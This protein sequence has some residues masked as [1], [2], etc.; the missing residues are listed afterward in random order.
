MQSWVQLHTYGIQ[1]TGEKFKKG[2]MTDKEYKSSE[3][4]IRVFELLHF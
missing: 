1:K 3:G 2:F 4:K